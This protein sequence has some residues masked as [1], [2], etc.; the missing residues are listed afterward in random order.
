MY[1][2]RVE[3]ECLREPQA[4]SLLYLRGERDKL[5]RELAF[6]FDT[7]IKSAWIDDIISYRAPNS[8][9]AH[10]EKHLIDNRRFDTIKDLDVLYRLSLRIA[11]LERLA[12]GIPIGSELAQ[13]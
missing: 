2:T 8:G 6:E 12:C 3:F 7:E 11:K 10:A 1:L 9:R 13:A 4:S 5:A